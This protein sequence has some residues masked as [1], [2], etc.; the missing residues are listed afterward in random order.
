MANGS[1]NDLQTLLDKQ[2]ITELLYRYCRGCDRRDQEMLLA[3][4]HPDAQ[5]D[6]GGF[7]GP[8]ADWV[9]LALAWLEGRVAVTHMVTNPLIWV[10]GDRAISDCHFLAY[11]RLPTGKDVVEEVVVKGRYLDRHV[12][13][14]D[15]WRIFHRVGI[16]DLEYRQE[17]PADARPTSGTV[18]SNVLADDPFTAIFAAFRA[19]R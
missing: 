13:C 17:L 1:H 11:N 18:R 4:F 10:D 16:H 19:G 6:H 14:Q 7:V 2:A 3:C 8:T 12:R 5:H 9:P 15:G